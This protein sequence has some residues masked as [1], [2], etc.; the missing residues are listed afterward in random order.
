MNWFDWYNINRNKERLEEGY[1][2][3]QYIANLDNKNISEIKEYNKDNN[4][5]NWDSINEKTGESSFITE[6]DYIDRVGGN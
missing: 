5:L 6:N 3:L 1:S 2:N 4:Y